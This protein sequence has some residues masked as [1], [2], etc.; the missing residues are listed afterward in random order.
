MVHE[1]LPATNVGTFVAVDMAW[2]GANAGFRRH[3]DTG[4]PLKIIKKIKSILNRIFIITI[5]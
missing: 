4:I 2:S 1:N 5:L 3:R